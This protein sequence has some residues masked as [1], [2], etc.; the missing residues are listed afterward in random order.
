MKVPRKALVNISSR[1]VTFWYWLVGSSPT[2]GTAGSRLDTRSISKTEYRKL[3]FIC[4]SFEELNW[5]ALWQIRQLTLSLH[6]SKL[7]FTREISQK[8]NHLIRCEPEHSGRLWTWT[9][10]QVRRDQFKAFSSQI[11]CLFDVMS[12]VQWPV[13]LVFFFLWY[14]LSLKREIRSKMEELDLR[15]LGH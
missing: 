10:C 12:C 6:F 1:K 11:R 9:G 8:K 5:D 3:I 2:L 7:S 14:F 13:W 4:T 15:Y